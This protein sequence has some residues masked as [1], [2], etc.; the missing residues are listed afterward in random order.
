MIVPEIFGINGSYSEPVRSCENR[1]VPIG[2]MMF[3]FQRDCLQ[4]EVRIDCHDR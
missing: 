4:N 2:E 1:A 3:L